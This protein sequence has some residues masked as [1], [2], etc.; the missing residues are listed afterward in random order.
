[1]LKTLGK[2]TWDKIKINEVFAYEACWAILIKVSKN[3]ALCLTVTKI[4]SYHSFI[5]EKCRWDGYRFRKCGKL[6]WLTM[7]PLTEPPFYRLPKSVQ[8]LFKEE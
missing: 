1:M 7:S 8:K 4:F 5:G 3:K 2:T 6:S